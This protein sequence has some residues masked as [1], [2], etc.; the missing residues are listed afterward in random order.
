MKKVTVAAAAL[1]LALTGCSQG[2]DQP[3]EPATSMITVTVANQAGVPLEGIK[4]WTQQIVGAAELR[5]IPPE[6]TTD[7]SGRAVLTLP[8]N[9][10]AQIGLADASDPA[11]MEAWQHGFTVPTSDVS[12]YYQYPMT[13]DCDIVDP[14]QPSS[15]P[16]LPAPTSSP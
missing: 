1:V 3:T 6:A 16:A 10:T 11:S 7:A 4:V 9:I 8:I 14:A 2:G 13:L 15:C 12:L 5:D